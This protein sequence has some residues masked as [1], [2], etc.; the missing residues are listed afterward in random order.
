MKQLG[1]RCFA[2]LDAEKLFESS[3]HRTRMKELIDC[4]GNYPFFTKGLCKCMY[5]SAWDEEHFKIML[6]MLMT[7]SLE[8]E[9]DTGEMREQG[10]VLVEA[11]TGGEQYVYQLSV[12]FLDGTEFVLDENAELDPEFRHIIGRALQAAEVIDRA[13]ETE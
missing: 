10:D 4:Y 7:M 2:A 13:A 11:H 12:S 9:R 5:L 8:S 6:E 3:A 1:E